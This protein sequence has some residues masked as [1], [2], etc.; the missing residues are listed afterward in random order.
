MDADSLC[1]KCIAQTVM[2][3]IAANGAPVIARKWFGARCAYPVDGGLILHDGQALFGTS[4]TWRGLAAG[5]ALPAAIAPLLSLPPQL[6][7]L[8]GFFSMCGDLA[9]SFIKR[10]L[11]YIPSSCMRLIDAPLE[12]LLPAALMQAPLGLGSTG[13]IAAAG[14]FFLLEVL[15]SPL[16]Y[17][18][19]IRNRPY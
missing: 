9:A 16:L 7:A 14:A 19:R 8:F 5:V 12:A 17:R 11:G 10:R 13:V 15:F 6:G 1:L 18:W 2:L 3:L 4:K